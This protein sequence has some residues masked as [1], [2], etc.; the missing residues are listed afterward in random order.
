MPEAARLV[1]LDEADANNPVLAGAK[2]SRLA[3]ARALGLPVLNGLVVPAEISVPAIRAGAAAL[4]ARDNSGAARTAV[5]NRR[6]PHLLSQLPRAARAL[7]DSLVV[8]SSSTAGEDGMWAGAFTSYVGLPAGDLGTGVVGC[9]A[10][11]FNPDT[12]KRFRLVGMRPAEIGMAVLIQPEL[13]TVCG[14]V[15]T[16]L[17]RG[18]VT[19]AAMEGHHGSLVAGWETGKVAV[20]GGDNSIR[21]AEDSPLSPELLHG[22]ARL[23]R[24]SGEMIGYPHIEWALGEDRELYLLQAQPGPDARL[25][26]LR[27]AAPEASS[28]PRALLGEV[29]RMMIRYPGPVGERL[30]WPWAVGLS[31]LPPVRSGLP[32]GDPDC[33]MVEIRE[34]ARILTGQRWRGTEDPMRSLREIRDGDS[35][36]ALEWLS[37]PSKVDDDLKRSHLEKLGELAEALTQVGAIPHPGWMWYFD[38][39][40]PN[41]SWPG[42]ATASRRVGIGKWD[43]F[44]YGVIATLGET[45][46]GHPAAG[47]WGAGRL[48]YIRTADQAGAFAPREVIL[49][50]Q[51]IGNLAPLLW[52][53]AGLVTAEGSPAAHLF[54]VATWLGVPAVCGV[55]IKPWIRGDREHAALGENPIVAVDGDRGRIALL[56]SRHDTLLRETTE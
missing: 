36:S 50:D 2:A 6:P 43:P 12:V 22:V 56:P 39:D 27:P 3:E 34:S 38:P 18:E 33:L 9:W 17:Q 8:R 1:W 46:S 52:D 5:Y 23:A 25:T 28:A 20:V 35:T 51:P 26:H 49:T 41:R 19:I 30:V 31:D 15:A 10:S 44:I 11:V 24:R 14:G 42:R 47:G 54:E 37:H 7:G 40:S 32:T 4:G 53:A 48:R 55:D 16:R 21:G 13:A 29:V 45:F